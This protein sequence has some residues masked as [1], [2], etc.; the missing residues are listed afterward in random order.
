MLLFHKHQKKK[1]K[2]DAEIPIE[3]VR[4]WRK[5]Y[6]VSIRRYEVS[7]KKVRSVQSN[8]VPCKGQRFEV[9]RVRIVL[10]PPKPGAERS[11]KSHANSCNA[12]L[13]N[14]GRLNHKWR[15]N[16]LILNMV[17]KASHVNI[18]TELIVVVS[19]NSPEKCDCIFLPP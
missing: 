5:I 11:P 1:K 15:N 18:I 9:S 13:N 7:C 19:P 16:Y 8:F 6:E 12:Q 14:G 17:S 3:Y 10:T 4:A 2:N